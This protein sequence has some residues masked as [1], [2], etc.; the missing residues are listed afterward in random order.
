MQYKFPIVVHLYCCAWR[1]IDI[2][3]LELIGFSIRC[4]LFLAVTTTNTNGISFPATSTTIPAGA[5]AAAPPRPLRRLRGAAAPRLAGWRPPG[6]A[7]E[8]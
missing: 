8:R 5:A 4:H 7:P 1:Y 2:K 6:R 3:L